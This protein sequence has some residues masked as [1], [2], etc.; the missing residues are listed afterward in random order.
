M[1]VSQAEKA[2]KFRVLHERP[3]AFVI[4]NP[5]DAGSARILAGLGFEALASSSGAKAG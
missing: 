3:G 5:W 2:R 4:A 1:S